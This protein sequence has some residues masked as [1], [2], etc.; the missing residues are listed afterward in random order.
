[1]F[2]LILFRLTFRTIVW[3][4]L[5]LLFDELVRRMIRRLLR[6]DFGLVMLWGFLL[7]FGV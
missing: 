1:M 2:A 7:G 5:G 3:D 6:V 4:L